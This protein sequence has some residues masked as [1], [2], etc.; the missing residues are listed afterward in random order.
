LGY[1]ITGVT[2]STAALDL[3]ARSPDA[4]DLVITD[5]TMPTLTGDILGQRIFALRPDIPI[6]ICTGYSEKLTEA[7]IRSLGFTGIA[8]KPII[9]K[10]LATIVRQSLDK[11]E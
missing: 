1:D 8:Y 3:F 2:D 11:G 9:M 7:S 10:E 6:V 5:M 4:Y